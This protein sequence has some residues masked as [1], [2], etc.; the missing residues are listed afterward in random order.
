MLTSVFH[1][2]WLLWPE[3][4]TQH[5]S[6]HWSVQLGVQWGHCKPPLWRGRGQGQSPMETLVCFIYPRFWNSF[7]MHHLV[8]KFFFNYQI[9]AQKCWMLKQGMKT[10]LNLFEPVHCLSFFS[11]NSDLMHFIQFRPSAISFPKFRSLMLMSKWP[12]KQVWIL[13]LCSR[14]L[15]IIYA[16]IKGLVSNV[17]YQ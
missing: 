8:T 9:I 1:E 4:I 16:K 11:F 2:D 14:P 15:L 17:D 12:W 13:C 5:A 6:A 7:S 3:P 10:V